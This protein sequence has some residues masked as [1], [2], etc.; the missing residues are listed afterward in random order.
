M[1]MPFKYLIARPFLVPIPQLHQ[2][3]ICK[4]RAG[5]SKSEHRNGRQNLNVKKKENSGH[6]ALRFWQR[7]EKPSYNMRT[8]KVMNPRYK[9]NKIDAN[10]EVHIWNAGYDIQLPVG[11]TPDDSDIEWYEKEG[12]IEHK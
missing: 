11:I 1:S 4:H 5:L 12:S 7:K 6:P 10:A 8:R 9:G 3:I 2:H